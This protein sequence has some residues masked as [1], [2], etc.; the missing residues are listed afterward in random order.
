[1]T[2]VP[3]LHHHL[4]SSFEFFYASCIFPPPPPSLFFLFP[5]WLSLTLDAHV[6]EVCWMKIHDFLDRESDTGYDQ[7]HN[8]YMVVSVQAATIGCIHGTYPC[9]FLCLS[10][11]FCVCVISQEIF[12]RKMKYVW[13][14]SDRLERDEKKNNLSSCLVNDVI[15]MAEFHYQVSHLVISDFQKPVRSFYRCVCA[16]TNVVRWNHLLYVDSLPFRLSIFFCGSHFQDTDHVMKINRVTG[17]VEMKTWGKTWS[18]S[19]LQ[20][21]DL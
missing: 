9:L 21:L 14:S 20:S 17:S 1:M 8:S 15:C 6:S 4:V 5:T 13:W 2:R 19:M 12:E 10:C 11:L 3:K 18:F 7:S 16:F